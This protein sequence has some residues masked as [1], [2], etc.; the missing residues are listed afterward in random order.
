MKRLLNPNGGAFGFVEH[1]AVDLNNDDEKNLS[2]LEF[3]QKAFDPLQ[4]AVAHNC[5]LHRQTEN[6]ISS[7]FGIPESSSAE[8]LEKER[9]LVKDMWPVSCQVRGVVKFIT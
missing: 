6:V 8:M 4:Q 1:V 3:Q 7:V 9:F 5:H 2:F